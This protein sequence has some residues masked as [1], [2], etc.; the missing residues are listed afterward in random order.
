MEAKGQTR[1][2]PGKGAHMLNIGTC[3]KGERLLDE[4]PSVMEAGFETIEVYFDQGLRD[5]ELEALAERARD[6]MAGRVT[7]S[8]IGVYV[9][10]LADGWQ[11]AEVERCIECA[12]LF[13]APVVSTFAGAL[14]G[15]PVFAAMERF[16][17]VF[18]E[19]TRRA[20]DRGVK[21]G[22]ENA[23]CDGFWYRAVKNIGFCPGAWE[24]MFDA[25]GSDAL[26][27]T[28][29]PSHQMEQFIDVYDQL[30]RWTP[31]IFHVHG[32]DAKID[33]EHVRRYGAWFGQ[34]YCDHRFPGL[35]DSDWTRIMALLLHHGYQGSITIEGY[36][37]PVFHDDREM[38]GQINALR[39]LRQCR[40]TLKNQ[41]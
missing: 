37:D 32:K 35:G 16:S 8:A 20:E 38:E 6:M 36:H 29:E 41:L 25:V 2:M 21:I 31:R 39:Y 7:V 17:G 14:D 28:W 1:I 19:L 23:H 12:P 13:G 30:E 4:L 3:V 26:G 15:A 5:T 9:N 34:H 24:M 22:I 11:R 27:L 40:E 33:M 18:G 10:P